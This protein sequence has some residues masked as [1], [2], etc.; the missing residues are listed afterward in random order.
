MILTF[1]L[2]SAVYSGFFIL[3]LES[4]NKSTSD[5]LNRHSRGV[6]DYIWDWVWFT[7]VEELEHYKIDLCK[8]DWECTYFLFS[9]WGNN[10]LVVTPSADFISEQLDSA[11][12]WVEPIAEQVNSKVVQH[13]EEV[14]D[15]LRVLLGN[16]TK[17]VPPFEEVLFPENFSEGDDR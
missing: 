5:F 10:L 9:R 12:E 17:A 6:V 11:R 7:P 4:Y 13:C 3:L 1:L 8:E 2:I 16:M 15:N 14:S